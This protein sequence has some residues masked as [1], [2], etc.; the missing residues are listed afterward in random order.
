MGK[1]LNSEEIVIEKYDSFGGRDILL[2]GKMDEFEIICATVLHL[3][4]DNQ[5]QGIG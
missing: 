1:Y 4:N 2:I 3:P 5:M